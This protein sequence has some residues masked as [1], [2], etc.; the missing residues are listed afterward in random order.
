MGQEVKPRAKTKPSTARVGETS[1]DRGLVV[2]GGCES[3]QLNEV[4]RQPSQRLDFLGKSGNHPDRA[5]PNP[6]VEVVQQF[7]VAEAADLA[8]VSRQAILKSVSEKRLSTTPVTLS[9]GPRR[10]R[11][12]HRITAADLFAL[13]PKAETRWRVRKAAELVA[14]QMDK[15][16]TEKAARREQIQL[17]NPATTD[18]GSAKAWHLG[19]FRQF[20]AESGHAKKRALSLYVVAVL[21]K[22]I[23]VPDWVLGAH[24]K[25]SERSLERWQA[26]LEGGGAAAL[27]P[28]YHGTTRSHFEQYPEQ[29]TWL[30][31]LLLNRPHASARLLH[32]A[33]KAEFQADAPAVDAVLRWKRRYLAEHARE[34]LMATNPDKYKNK[35]QSAMGSRSAHVVRL[36]QLWE[37]DATKADLMFTGDPRRYTLCQVVDV[38]SDRRRFLVVETS[39]GRAHGLL[40]RRCILEWGLPEQL[41]TDNGKDYTS[42]YITRFVASLAI[43]QILCAPFSGEEKPH[44]E[45]GFRT[46]LHDLVEL[47]EGYTGHNVAQA[48]D[49]RARRSFAQRLQEAKKGEVVETGMTREEF[50]L[51]VERWCL[52]DDHR[53]RTRGRLKG[54]TPAQMVDAWAKEHPVRR[55]HD[56]L[57]LDYLLA[58]GATKTVKKKGIEHQRRIFMAPELGA[59]IGRQVEIRLSPETPGRIAVFQDGVFVC[60]AE[61]PELVD[62][63]R[64]EVAARARALQKAADK[65]TRAVHRELKAQV[66]PAAVLESILQQRLRNVDPTST[67]QVSEPVETTA[68]AAAV[69]A[70]V[71]ENLAEEARR[72]EAAPMVRQMPLSPA[73]ELA[74]REFLARED[75]EDPRERYIRLARQPLVSAE[76]RDWMDH[77][78][79]TPEGLGLKKAF[80]QFQ[81]P[82]AQ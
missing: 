57:A 69:A 21:E 62:V 43:E 56:P 78:E 7:S 14:A 8:M 53:E 26:A 41:K 36:N 52:A 4:S 39:S 11:I 2:Q 76:D 54:Q 42:K 24:Q 55:I 22:T 81:P 46:F 67:L 15:A 34:F 10:G 9:D 45:R 1:V 58:D 65:A 72:Q 20:Q 27:D 3:G 50:E 66:K 28:R 47:I 44:V 37:T 40:L 13:H 6:V 68:T 18:R 30:E 31:G 12:E 51:F 71:A 19:R 61:D 29:A 38:Y 64:A 5:L 16:E 82:K 33:L 73:Q 32:E 80:Q 77:F 70:K 25:L 48:Q 79:T 75:R 35:Y 59:I 74:A 60:H 23:E 63:N 17:A 49:I